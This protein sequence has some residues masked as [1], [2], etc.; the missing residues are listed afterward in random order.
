[1]AANDEYEQRLWTSDCKYVC[2]VDEVGCGSLMGP[3]T[4]ACVVFSANIDY[5]TLLKG[6]N[7]SKQ[8]T[9]EQREELYI[10]IKQYALD[11]SVAEA[12]VEEID[13]YNIYWAK[14]M[15]ARRALT[16][17]K[18]QPD[19]ILM[20]GNHKIPE[21]S[22]PQTAIVKGDSKSIS[23]AGA[24]ILAKVDRDRYIV[25]LAKEVVPEY[26]WKDNKGYYTEEHIAALKKYGKTQ[27]HRAKY[28]SKF[29]GGW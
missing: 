4:M 23:I 13:Q 5:K 2:G 26:G 22:I 12:S 29:I 6:L 15:A 24:S 10:K 25:E 7:D 8:K 27:W 18:I 20:D 9:S 16:K 11:W 1:M 28:V 19:H 14:W 21:I 17:L 3:V